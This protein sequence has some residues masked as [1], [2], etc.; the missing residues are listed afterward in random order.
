YIANQQLRDAGA[1]ASFSAAKN[2]GLNILAKDIQDNSNNVTRFIVLARTPIAPSAGR[3]FKT[4]IVFALDEGPGELFKAL[5]AF[6]LRQINLTKIESRPNQDSKNGSL[7][8]F[9]YIFH[10]D[11]EA[12]MLDKPAQNAVRNLEEFASFV[13]VLGSYPSDLNNYSSGVCFNV[14]RIGARWCAIRSVDSE[15]KD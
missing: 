5:A 2:Y 15:T 12:S 14:H 4:S 13:R 6:S 1:I 8:L 3:P 7:K 9:N 10:L 11:F